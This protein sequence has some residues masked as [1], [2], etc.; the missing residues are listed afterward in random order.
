MADRTEREY[1][2]QAPAE[3]VG[4]FLQQ[5]IFPYLSAFMD[6]QFQGI[7]APDSTPYTYTGDRVAQFDPREAYG[8]DLSDAAIG[9]YRPYIAEASDYYR[10]AGDVTYGA[11]AEGTDLIRGSYGEGLGYFDD[12]R[13]ATA[14]GRGEYDP[15]TASKYFDPY[16]EKVV[17]QTLSD[18]SKGLSK[19]DMALR[20]QAV[21]SGA[22]GG[23]RGRLTQE[24]LAE[25]V[26]R[27][28]A[29]T[30]A[31]IRS[32]GY[33]DALTRGIGAYESAR[34]RDITTGGQFGGLGTGRFGLGSQAGQ[35]IY[36]IGSGIGGM[37]T[38]LGGATSGLGTTL[39]GLQ[40][41]DINRTM[42]M[43]AM[44]RGRNQAL[45]DRA[46]SD[47]VGTYNLP[48]TTLGNVGSVVSAL[49]P[50]AGGYG[51]AGADQDV[52]LSGAGSV[53]A[54]NRGQ[55]PGYGNVGTGG[56]GY[57]GGYGGGIYGTTVGTNTYGNNMPVA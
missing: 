50:M 36:G 21:S 45:M 37:F 9:S 22:Y 20:D 12:A 56:P 10:G 7:G 6:S 55:L 53:Y 29:E 15:A 57:G 38:G 34:G 13:A 46:Y 19:G 16:E 33:G 17:E 3:Y 48:M 26:G 51:F 32:K 24:E 52:A 8:M 39:A 43:G 11:G 30:V 44:G 35:G 41:Q 28:A 18:I 49:G 47:F 54:P 40:G 1:T 42:G 27:G 2:T 25:R 23:S 4:G 14:A 31:G 5:G